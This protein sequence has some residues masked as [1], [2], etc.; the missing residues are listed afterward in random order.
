VRWSIGLARVRCLPAI[1][2]PFR[3]LIG[4]DWFLGCAGFD[5]GALLTARYRRTRSREYWSYKFNALIGP[6]VDLDG[7]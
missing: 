3:F 2:H 7:H 4:S 5:P 6:R 1:S